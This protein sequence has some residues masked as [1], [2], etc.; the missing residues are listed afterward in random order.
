M[1]QPSFVPRL[2]RD[3]DLALVVCIMFLPIVWGTL[4]NVGAF[5]LESFHISMFLIIGLTFSRPVAYARALA[6]VRHN[7]LFFW[8]FIVFLFLNLFSYTKTLD[9]KALDAFVIKQ[10]AFLV[11]CLAVAVRV[12]DRPL[13][14]PSLYIGG[15]L[16]LWTFLAALSLSAHTA[17]T[18]L[19]DA[20]AGLV[21]S[22]NYQA[23]TF[24]F[25]R[26][27]FNAFSSHGAA[28]D[29]E[30]VTSLKNNVATG[31]LVAYICF[32]AGATHF[33]EYRAARLFDIL[34]SC[35]FLVAS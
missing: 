20:L 9:A 29:L 34:L 26:Q 17:G 13:L 35:L 15:A 25:L 33:M 23:W 11:M 6:I 8:A 3:A 12:T 10:V 5:S 4:F 1:R 22:G 18:S 31:L 21:A 30:F 32:R 27:V 16:S 7:W 28:A 14:A 2:L 24:G 19:P